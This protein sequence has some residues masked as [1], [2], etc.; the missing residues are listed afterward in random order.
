MK[1]FREKNLRFCHF[2]RDTGFRGGFNQQ[3]ND[4]RQ[5]TGGYN[6]NQSDRYERRYVNNNEELSL[7]VLSLDHCMTILVRRHR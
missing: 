6:R 3:S 2:K 7:K 5:G 4:L 1:I